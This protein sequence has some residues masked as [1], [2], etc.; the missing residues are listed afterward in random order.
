MDKEREEQEEPAEGEEEEA[1]VE[2]RLSAAHVVEFE[3]SGI[4][5]T[6]EAPL[7]RL[8]LFINAHSEAGTYFEGCI[9]LLVLVNVAAGVLSTVE[10]FKTDAAWSNFFDVIEPVSV[11]IFTGEYLLRIAAIGAHAEYRASPVLGRGRWALTS[12][13]PLVDLLAI[14]PFYIDL[15]IPKA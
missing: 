2:V 15:A 14:V 9:L 8:Y 13:F 7:D 1:E 3:G 5:L 6:S 4:S 12:F 11:A 10:S